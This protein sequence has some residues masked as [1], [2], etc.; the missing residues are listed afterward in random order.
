MIDREQ[1]RE[2]AEMYTKA[3]AIRPDLNRAYIQRG[4]AN[5]N[6]GNLILA[7]ADHNRALKANP[8]IAELYYLRGIVYRDQKKPVQAAAD[9]RQALKVD[10]SYEDARNE[11]ARLSKPVQKGL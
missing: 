8:T 11:L 5:Y 1:F 9:M 2:A 10:P 4:W 3:I 6:I 7:L